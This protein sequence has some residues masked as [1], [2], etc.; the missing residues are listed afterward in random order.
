MKEQNTKST[1]S[2][3]KAWHTK[4]DNRNCFNV[5][6]NS[7][8]VMLTVYQD[9]QPKS[10]ARIKKWVESDEPELNPILFSED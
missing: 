8:G 5:H 2:L 1:V 3:I 4:K 9:K 6:I 10:Y 7:L